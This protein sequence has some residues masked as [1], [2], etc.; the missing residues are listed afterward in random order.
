MNKI[1]NIIESLKKENI[2]EF[3][4]KLSFLTLS[5]NLNETFYSLKPVKNNKYY[6][7]SIAPLSKNEIN[8]IFKK[9]NITHK[10]ELHH[11]YKF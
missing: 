4:L 2:T 8:A 5:K 10:I 6:G 9:L 7:Y 1:N 3:Y 11:K